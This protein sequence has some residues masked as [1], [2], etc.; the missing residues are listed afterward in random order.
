MVTDS[1]SYIAAGNN[2]THKYNEFFSTN[3][4]RQDLNRRSLRGGMAVTGA[5]ILSSVIRIGATAALARLLVPGDFGLLSMVTAISVFAERFK[6][7]GLSDATVQ[8]ES[9][10]HTQVTGLFWINVVVC[11]CIAVILASLSTTIAWFYRESRLVSVSLVIS[12]TF[13]F[14]GL[15]IQHHAL[16]RRQLRFG[17]LAA[18][19]L[20][21]IALSQGL[22]IAV[23]YYGFGYWALVAREFSRSLFVVV[24]T[25]IIC[26]WRPGR[27]QR[28]AG[29]AT[30]M[31]FGRNVTAF[32]VVN[33]LSQSVDRILIGRLHGSEWLGLYD[34][35]H[36]VLGMPVNQMRYPV[37][38]VALPALSA[39][40]GQP[41]KFR[42]YYERAS[43]LV[44]FAVTPVVVFT[45][46][47]SDLVV[48]LLLGPQWSKSVPILRIIAVG[49]LVEPFV[50]LVGPAL[51][52]CGKTK[53]YFRLGLA[54]SILLVVLVLVG[55]SL[56]GTMGVALAVATNTLFSIA[57]AM[58]Y[59]L[60]YL[61]VE[62]KH[63]LPRQAFD[64]TISVLWGAMLAAA[65]YALGWSIKA[66]WILF[67]VIG[68]VLLYFALWRVV[69]GG[70]ERLSA[71][72]DY[73]ARVFGKK[74]VKK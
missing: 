44:T 60:R 8:I 16:L 37:N 33:F 59:G 64:L 47:F 46:I 69:P 45:F 42:A 22:A 36:K 71:Y 49:A 11:T 61:P 30:L 48:A 66:S 62:S 2:V 55:G 28:K 9:I 18:I 74:E 25:W 68:G 39:L 51:V 41:D 57:L 13:I 23:A 27:P 31:S 56:W 12:S 50:Q 17:A 34:N 26:S 15:V 38:T 10:N 72:R 63:L 32:N 58:V 67:Y 65:R 43:R 35:A 6:D 24:G 29:I 40:Q 19:Q 73:F 1:V 21:S 53:E 5:E 52:A 54:S 70:R 20:S 14:S 7:L 4:L 3:A